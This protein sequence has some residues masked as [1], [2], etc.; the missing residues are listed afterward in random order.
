MTPQDWVNV[1][2]IELKV[3]SIMLLAYSKQCSKYLLTL[4]LVKSNTVA[5]VQFNYVGEKSRPRQRVLTMQEL[6]TL[7]SR[8]AEVDP[9][10]T[11]GMMIMMFMG[12]RSG[13]VRTMAVGDVNKD[14]TIWTVPEDKSKTD[15]S[16]VRP[17]PEY[18]RGHFRYLMENGTS[19]EWCSLGG[20]LTRY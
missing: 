14:F 1:C 15:V 20:I 2:K 17:I 10:T 19:A 18:V 6:G 3:T 8:C 16:I 9:S 11:A 12:A 4:G 7:Y 13:E 5:V